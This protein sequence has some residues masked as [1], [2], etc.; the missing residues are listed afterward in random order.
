MEVVMKAELGLLEMSWSLLGGRL[1]PKYGGHGLYMI[2][3]QL[4]KMHDG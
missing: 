3:R 2:T 4:Y 1:V